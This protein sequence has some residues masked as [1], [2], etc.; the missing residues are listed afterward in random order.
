MITEMTKDLNENWIS[1][2]WKRNYKVAG[3][4][5]RLSKLRKM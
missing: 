4:T 1:N 3:E 5:L 2:T